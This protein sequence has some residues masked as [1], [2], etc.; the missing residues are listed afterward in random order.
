MY[1]FDS[2]AIV[3]LINNKPSFNKFINVP[4][5]TSALNIAEIH[6]VFLNLLPEN[7]ANELIKSLRITLI[8]PDRDTAITASLFRFHNKKL[9]LSYADCL[10]YCLAQSKNLIFLTGDDAFNGTKGVE[11]VK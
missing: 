2:Y 8:E 9:K 5:I 1:F 10:G 6:S 4:I 11:F 7:K 3:E